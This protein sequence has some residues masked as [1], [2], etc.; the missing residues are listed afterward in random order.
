MGQ[1]EVLDRAVTRDSTLAR[2]AVDLM[3]EAPTV[4]AGDSREEAVAVLAGGDDEGIPVLDADGRDVTARR[5]V[6]THRATMA[7]GA[8]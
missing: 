7:G 6:V 4:R 5:G 2:L 1:R 3:R 8:E